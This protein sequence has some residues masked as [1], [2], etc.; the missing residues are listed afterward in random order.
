[1]SSFLS[2]GD[3][4]IDVILG[5]LDK[6]ALEFNFPVLDNDYVQFA[7]ARL[8]AFRGPKDWLIAFE[9]LGFS[10]REVEFVD[11][12]YVYGSCVERQ[13]IIGQEIP[14]ASLPEQPLFDPDTNQG[15]ADWRHWSVRIGAEKLSFSPSREKYANAG[16]A[17]VRESGPGSLTEIGILRFLVHR[18]NER[19]LFM[20]DENLLRK[21]PRCQGL[22]KFVQTTRWQHPD[23]SAGERPSQNQSMRT[24]IQ[25]LA[26]GDASVFDPGRPN[27][28]W[29][30]WV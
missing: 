15:I 28:S 24:L 20:S 25:A 3:M 29:T 16:I 4:N 8:G 9:V 26:E 30:S 22:S 6:H 27:T 7:G 2:S 17:I 18:F 5:D 19:K 1:M 12:L 14:V 13:G 11:D 10:N 21:F 23:I